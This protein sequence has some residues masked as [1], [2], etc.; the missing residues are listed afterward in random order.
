MLFSCVTVTLRSPYQ[1]NDILFQSE[2]SLQQTIC[3]S[4]K[5]VTTKLAH[6]DANMPIPCLVFVPL[7]AQH[8]GITLTY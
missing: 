4:G 6:A 8:V 3:A 1:H 5:Y 2:V 7:A